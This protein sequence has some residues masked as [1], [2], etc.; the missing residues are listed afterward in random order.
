M[1]SIQ[2]LQWVAL[3][4]GASGAEGLGVTVFVAP[5]LEPDGEA[6]TLADF[7]DLAGWPGASLDLSWEVALDN[8]VR[9]IATRVSPAPDAALWPRLFPPTLPVRRFAPDD[10]LD[11]RSRPRSAPRSPRTPCAPRTRERWVRPS[12]TPRRPPATDN[13]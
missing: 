11:R 4:S 7:P 2:R 8:G 6:A 13:S 3:P 9:M 1:T 5:Q 12:A 10:P